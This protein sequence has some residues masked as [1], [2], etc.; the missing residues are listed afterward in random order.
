MCVPR[1]TMCTTHVY[2]VY[3]TLYTYT[4]VTLTCI[5]TIKKNSL[6]YKLN[7]LL[8]K[9]HLDCLIRKRLIDSNSRERKKRQLMSDWNIFHKSSKITYFYLLCLSSRKVLSIK[10][11]SIDKIKEKKF[12]LLLHKSCISGDA[13]IRDSL[14]TL[15]NDE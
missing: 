15:A 1:Y 12:Y 4:F 11:L 3:Y 9:L 5:V 8:T 13:R 7:I 14:D 10:Q 6:Y 2:I